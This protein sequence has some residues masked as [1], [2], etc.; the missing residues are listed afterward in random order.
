[1]ASADEYMEHKY[2]RP[3]TPPA[4]ET[5]VGGYTIVL[6]MDDR[7]S[8]SRSLI[9]DITPTNL[10]ITSLPIIP[11]SRFMNDTIP[12]CSSFPPFL[13]PFDS[14]PVEITNQILLGL[15][16]FSLLL[17]PRTNQRAQE[18]V[19]TIPGFLAVTAFP[20]LLS[21]LWKMRCSSQNLKD[22]LRCVE[23]TDCTFC[24]KFGDLLPLNGAERLC[25]DCM[26]KQFAGGVQYSSPMLPSSDGKEPING[27]QRQVFLMLKENKTS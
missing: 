25:A 14:L 4:A 11:Q 23:N 9:L 10:R 12:R 22:L 18:L 7:L 26:K 13:G 1:M 6:P 8:R 2:N 3:L 27:L 17:F 21:G 20:G 16:V 24:G 15:D 19:E 5:S